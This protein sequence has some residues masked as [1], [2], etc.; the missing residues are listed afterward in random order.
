MHPFPTDSADR[1]RSLREKLRNRRAAIPV[2]TAAAAATAACGWL[3][4]SAEFRNAQNVAG[5]IAVRSELDPRPLL[6]LALG[7]G[8]SV[9]LPRITGAGAMVFVP[10]HSDSVMIPNRFGIPEPE[11]GGEEIAS[12]D[13]LDLVIVPLIGFD[14]DGTRLGTGAGYYD[15]A[16]AYKR[17]S[18]HRRPVLAGYAYALQQC[19]TLEAAEWDVPLDLVA[20]EEGIIRIGDTDGLSRGRS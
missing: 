12:N 8:K 6:D 16:F 3:A 15:R 19:N 20:T 11:T 5:Y 17:G 7:G 4:S 13:T 18:P 9:F 14:T 10:W 2:E 1:R